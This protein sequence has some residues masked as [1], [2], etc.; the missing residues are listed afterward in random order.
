MVNPSMEH[1]R[2][3]LNEQKFNQYNQHGIKQF[4][5]YNNV[6]NHQVDKKNNL[7]NYPNC[8]DIH[9]HI[10]NCPICSKFFK[11]NNVV[12]IIVIVILVILCILLLKKVL[13]I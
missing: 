3:I 12:Y 1:Q 7:N 6:L 2:Y 5:P 10:S 11:F 8:L 9:S 13:N 4:N